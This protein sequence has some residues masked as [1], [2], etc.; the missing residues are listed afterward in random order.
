[1]WKTSTLVAFLLLAGCDGYITSGWDLDLS[2]DS[3][4]CSNTETQQTAYVWRDD[5]CP[6]GWVRGS[7]NECTNTQ[8]GQVELKLMGDRWECPEGYTGGQTHDQCNLDRNVESGWEPC[9]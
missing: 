9:I 6:R 1:M 5:K 7:I 3:C 8:T 2:C 4:L